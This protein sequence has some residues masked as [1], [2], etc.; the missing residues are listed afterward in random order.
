MGV[1]LISA[2]VWLDWCQSSWLILLVRNDCNFPLTYA[3]IFRPIP[4]DQFRQIPS[5]PTARNLRSVNLLE[6][7]LESH[8]SL[9]R[10]CQQKPNVLQCYCDL[11][12]IAL[13]RLPGVGV[14]VGEGEGRWGSGVT[15]R[16][17]SSSHTPVPLLHIVFALL[18]ANY[19]CK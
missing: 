17:V 4:L 18:D 8:N 5:Q 19:L 14:G 7:I 13:H 1:P 11:F 3:A 10:V 12:Y 15:G 9:Y 6:P 16:N 2:S